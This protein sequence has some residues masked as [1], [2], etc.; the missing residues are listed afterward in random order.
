MGETINV[1]KATEITGE[2]S[3]IQSYQLQQQSQFQFSSFLDWMVLCA[4][5]SE[6]NGLKIHCNTISVFFY[7]EYQQNKMGIQPVRCDK[8]YLNTGL[9]SDIP[10]LASIMKKYI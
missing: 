1:P 3:F 2:L 7:V 9:C 10:Y 8:K 6:K 4:F 5:S